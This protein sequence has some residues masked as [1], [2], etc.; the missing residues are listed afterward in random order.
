MKTRQEIR[1]VIRKRRSALSEAEQIIAK[2]NLASSIFTNLYLRTKSNIAIYLSND[3]EC[4]TD[5]FIE[6]CWEQGINTF[7]P[8]IHPFSKGHLLFLAYDSNTKLIPN[9]Y[10]ILEPKLSSQTLIPLEQL[11]IIFTPLV[12]FD[13]VGNRLGMGGGYYDRTLIN[14]QAHTK[15][16][17]LAHDCQKVDTLPVE[18]WDVPLPEIITPT[19]HFKFPN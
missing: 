17:G 18:S 4:Q 7:L 14:K 19:Q 16:V 9:R 10:G 12:A 1:N 15:V 5:N 13:D 2:E 6:Q 11:D 8:V 3:G